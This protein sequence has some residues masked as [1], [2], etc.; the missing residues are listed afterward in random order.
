MIFPAEM[1]TPCATAARVVL[2]TPATIHYAA[3][4]SSMGIV[5]THG[6][7]DAYRHATA[8]RHGA[9]VV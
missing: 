3:C 1:G 8:V 5:I 2:D 4:G 9:W 7:I 6:T